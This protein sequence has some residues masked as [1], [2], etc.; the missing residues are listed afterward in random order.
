MATRITMIIA[1]DHALFI[2]GLKLLLKEE[3]DM[4]IMDVAND[5]RELLTLL[6]KQQPQIVLLD[7]NMPGLNGLAAARFIKQSYTSIKIIMLSTY[8]EDHLIE[9][10]RQHGAN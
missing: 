4:E 1:D 6:Q 10:A 5:G 2:E 7:I 3:P 9:K 8:Q